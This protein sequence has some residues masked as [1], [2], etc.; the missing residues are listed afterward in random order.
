MNN[1][2][3]SIK[4][5]AAPPSWDASFTPM[6]VGFTCAF[7]IGGAKL[8]YGSILWM[9]T[10]FFAIALIET[11]KHALNEI[12]DYRSG[13]DAMVDEEH[14]TPFSGGK[15][16]LNQGLASVGQL[17]AIA[18]V[19][20]GVA[21][22]IGLLI[23]YFLSLRIL[24]IGVIGMAMAVL[25]NAPQTGLIYKGWGEPC[26]FIAY[27]PVCTMGAYHMFVDAFSWI[28]FLLSLSLGFLIVNVLVINE[29]P[30]YEAD[31]KVNKRNWVV[32]LGKEQGLK[33]YAALYWAH[34]VPVILLIIFT[35]S[36][37]WL[38]MF[39]TV[40][41]YIGVLRN[42]RVNMNNIPALIPS[43]ANTVTIHSRC[44]IFADMV[45]VMLFLMDL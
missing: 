31:L 14:L 5:L 39:L 44:G 23:S 40:P 35:G 38:L 8:N 45:V 43:N 36:P 2:V 27:G 42:G 1:L 12:L 28:P 16:V 30:D 10:A 19:T 18:A 17:W 6:L 4:R 37:L 13:N 26:I 9:F 7:T 20:M 24:L 41:T 3:E 15:K 32:R 33:L 22:V 11:G 25:Y 21:C 34:L 29:F